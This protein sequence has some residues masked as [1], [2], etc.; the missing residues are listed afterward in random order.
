LAIKFSRI[1]YTLS[2]ELFEPGSATP[3]L[4]GL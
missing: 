3:G 4:T 2:A 1:K